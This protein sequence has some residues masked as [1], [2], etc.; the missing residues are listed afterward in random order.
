M[1]RKGSEITSDAY[2]LLEMWSDK[3]NNKEERA[4]LSIKMIEYID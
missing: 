2:E 4:K 1:P 3:V